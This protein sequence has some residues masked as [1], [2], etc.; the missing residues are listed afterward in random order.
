M[1]LRIG[2]SGW[3]YPSG[4]GTWNGLFYPR[5]KG[6]ASA[7]PGFDEQ[8]R[9]AARRLGLAGVRRG[10]ALGAL[11][12]VEQADEVGCGDH[13]NA[14]GPA[15]LRPLDRG[16]DQAGLGLAGVDC[17][18]QHAGRRRDSPVQRKLAHRDPVAK[19]LGIGHAHRRQQRERDR[20]VVVAAFLREIGGRQV[21]R[22]ALG[23]ERQ[24]HR[25]QRGLHPFAAFAHRLVR[26]TD[27]IETRHP[28]RDLALHLDGARLQP[29][30]GNRPNQC[31]HKNPSRIE[32]LVAICAGQVERG[33][34]P[35]SPRVHR[36]P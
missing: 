29:Q 2:T 21:D 5:R 8:L 32:G 26:Q 31:D 18:Q 36:I 27:E 22:D 9:A 13:R 16:T 3:N 35:G 33:L 25:R 20:Q 23:R 14:A 4:K 17:R 6:R 19:L 1:S 10:Q 15:R 12:V 28:R 30:I 11:E 34:P 24:A 7:I